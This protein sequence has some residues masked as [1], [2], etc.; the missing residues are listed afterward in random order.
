[1]SQPQIY[2]EGQSGERYGYWIQPIDAEF[3][4]DPGNYIFAFKTQQNIWRPVYIGQ[5]S[6]LDQR[7]EYH[8]EEE[9]AKRYGA[10]H[11]HTHPSSS[12][13]TIRLAEEIDLVRQFTP[14]CNDQHV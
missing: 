1:M 12:D 11:I 6:D 2:W 7:L 14:A 8:N 4:N 9:C 10:T 5:T 13:E 3:S